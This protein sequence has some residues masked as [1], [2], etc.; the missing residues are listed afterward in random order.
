[1][2]S[3]QTSEN[4]DGSALPFKTIKAYFL[5]LTFL[6]INK[7]SSMGTQVYSCIHAVAKLYGLE[8]LEKFFISVY[9]LKAT[10]DY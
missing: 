8:S 10:D 2:K 9:K 4:W 7:L 3:W 1:M 5:A 6:D